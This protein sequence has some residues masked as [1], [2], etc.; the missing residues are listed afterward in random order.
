[1]KSLLLRRGLIPLASVALLAHAFSAGA[2]VQTTPPP[3]APPTGQTPPPATQAAPP[4]TGTSPAALVVQGGSPTREQIAA[5]IRS[6]GLTEAQVRDSL[7]AL[8][9][10]AAVIDAYFAPTPSSQPAEVSADFVAGLKKLGMFAADTTKPTSA[11]V[12]QAPGSL[13]GTV[14]GK[15]MF[16]NAASV[17]DPVTSG[18]VDPAYRLG[19]GDQLQFILT[20]AVEQAYA[21]DIRRDG[22]VVIPTIGQVPLAG[23]TLEGARS[24]LRQRSGDVYAAVRS[25][26][27]KLDLTISNIR[28]NS[29]FV[30]G[31]VESPGAYQVSALA[32]VF[33]G[34]ARAGGPSSH[35]SFREVELRRG[36]RVIKRIDFYRYLLDGDASED[37]RLEQSDVIYVPLNRRAVS[38]TGAVR[39]PRIFELTA[40]EGFADLMRFAGGPTPDANL[41]R[42]QVDRILPPTSRSPGRDRVKIDLLLNG[43]L[44]QGTAFPLID[45]DELTVFSVGTLRRNTL[46]IE[47]A[48]F[49]PGEFEYRPGI[50]VDSLLTRAKGLLPFAIRD[51]VLIQRLVP[52]TGRTESYAI[53]LDSAGGRSFALAEF[54]R[55]VILD[56]RRDYPGRSVFVTGAVNKPAELPF[57]EGETLR[58]VI[59]RAGGFTEGA[60]IVSFARRRVGDRFSDTTS[61]VTVYSTSQDFGPSGLAS[62]VVLQPFDRVDVRL[63]PGYREQRFVRVS[64]AFVTPGLYAIAENVDHVSTIV[65]R[66]GGVLPHAYYES[67]QL[68]RQGLPVAID[69]ER[70]L[71]GDAKEDLLVRPGDELF[72]DEDPAVVRVDGGVTRPSLIRYVPGRTVREYIELAGGPTERGDV[73][74]TVVDYPSGYSK[75]VHR[76]LGLW[77]S[78]PEVKSGAVI[79]VPVVEP[80]QH[81][82][83]QVF[84]R[85]AQAASTVVSLV[86]A[87]LAIKK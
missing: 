54:D 53:S 5:E 84:T 47:G 49:E 19:V 31:E 72:I 42:V 7:R 11:P 1:M 55:V 37:I 26:S 81:D 78:E 12:P 15:E 87:Y 41:D 13:A 85:I 14:F 74:K 27:A 70:A 71:R 46:S 36:G 80:Q 86:I 58:D 35:G 20:G 9:V 21:L 61:I 40:N 59:D 18:P 6:R 50:T 68:R 44:D 28:T 62:K 76:H 8:G 34:L 23:L 82:V 10:S 51:R 66:A 65:R 64:G 63:S 25:G 16:R 43:R 83:G 4:V 69:F 60:Q 38:V 29:I 45:G 75:R 17:F 52:Q 73:N 33:S 24:L 3:L 56:A 2:Q 77:T 79:H 48:V 57:L 67:F 32:T 30:I 22:S 39:R